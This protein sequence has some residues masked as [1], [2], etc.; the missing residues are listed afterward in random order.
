MK[1]FNTYVSGDF[2]PTSGAYVALHSTPHRLVH[3]EVYVEGDR[4]DSCKLCPLGVIYRLEQ[5]S[6]QRPLFV[7]LSPHELPAI[8]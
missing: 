4:F 1:I 7:N 2:A 5:T 8:Y 3:R 6:I